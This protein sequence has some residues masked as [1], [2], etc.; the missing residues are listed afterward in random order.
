MNITNEEIIYNIKMIDLLD[1]ICNKYEQ[2]ILDVFDCQQKILHTIQNIISQP[3]YSPKV[4]A[5]MIKN[6]LKKIPKYFLNYF[7]LTI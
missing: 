5:Q 6:T 1:D 2:N 3:N 4:L 7:L